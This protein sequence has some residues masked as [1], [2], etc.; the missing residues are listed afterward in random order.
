M[1]NLT[2]KY[3]NWK[4]KDS[5]KQQMEYI[6]D[7]FYQIVPFDLVKVFDSQDLQV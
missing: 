2:R 5:I 7:G 6:R 4:L 3:V 1:L